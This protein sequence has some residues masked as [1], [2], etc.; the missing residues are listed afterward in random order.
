MAWVLCEELAVT[1]MPRKQA[2]SLVTARPE[3]R[4]QAWLTSS[5][6]T[7][8]SEAGDSVPEEVSVA[9]DIHFYFLQV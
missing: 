3:V 5:G 6:V 2:Q 9:A 8:G 4:A 1:P 7:E